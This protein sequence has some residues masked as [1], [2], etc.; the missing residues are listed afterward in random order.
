MTDRQPTKPNRYAVYDDAH[1]FLRYEYHERADAPTQ[2]GDP[3]CKATL[4]PDDVAMALGLTGSPQVANALSKLSGAALRKAIPTRTVTTISAIPNGATV[5]CESNSYRKVATDYHGTAT[6]LQFLKFSSWE[7]M[8]YSTYSGNNADTS[9]TCAYNTLPNVLKSACVDVVLSDVNLTRKCFCLSLAELSGGISYFSSN[10]SRALSAGEY[11]TRT[12]YLQS[13]GHYLYYYVQSNGAPI[14]SASTEV[15]GVAPAFAVSD[16]L[17][18]YLDSDGKYYTEQAYT[19]SLIDM[20][21]A[22]F[23]LAYAKIATGSYTG[24]GTYGSSNKNTLTFPF[25]PKILLF[26]C[27]GA[28][29]GVYPWIIGNNLGVCTISGTSHYVNLTWG[30]NTISWYSTENDSTYQFNRSDRTYQ[31]IVI[32]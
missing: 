25:K 17:P 1:N 2:E 30:D 26:G 13:A 29:F 22:D 32:G 8:T 24:T 3:L 27:L 6:T 20:S 14:A 10:A 15:Y 21:G 28:A 31:Y 4:L 16:S 11:W 23:P 9:C 7:Q 18:V 5:V 19:R 12:F